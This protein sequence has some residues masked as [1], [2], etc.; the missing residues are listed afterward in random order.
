MLGMLRIAHRIRNRVARE[1]LRFREA[2]SDQR[3]LRS[4]DTIRATPLTDL[5][6]IE[7]VQE[8]VGSAGLA[9]DTRDVYGADERCMNRVARGLWQIPN[10]F[11]SLLVFLSDKEIHSILE[12]GTFTGYTFAVMMTYLTRFV[13]EA[14]GITADVDQSWSLKSACNGR[15]SAR[16]VTGTSELFLG[17]RFDLVFIDGDHAYQS[18]MQDY[19]RVGRLARFCAFHDINDQNVEVYPGNELG[20][21]RFWKEQILA[22]GLLAHEFLYQSEGRRVM[23]IGVVE[24]QPA[25]NT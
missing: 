5:K 14:R 15:F 19:E 6:N 7:R 24:H 18:V 2:Q 3:L 8:I 13:P 21:P 11:A 12:I 22:S 20:V 17:E 1:V 25:P 9:Y 23:G 10:Q 16:Y 4:L